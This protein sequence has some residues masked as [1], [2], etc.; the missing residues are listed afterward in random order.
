M[1]ITAI[2]KKGVGKMKKAIYSNIKVSY[3]CRMQLQRCNVNKESISLKKD[4]RPKCLTIWKQSSSNL[5]AIL[6]PSEMRGHLGIYKQTILLADKLANRTLLG[7]ETQ[8][9]LAFMGQR[10]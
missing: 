2:E 6:L 9:Q 1:S 5:P 4:Q 3:N 8:M 7:A 10:P